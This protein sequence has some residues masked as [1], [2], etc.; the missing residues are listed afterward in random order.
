MGIAIGLDFGTT[1]SIVTYEDRKGRLR[2]YK[3]NGS[4]LIP[5]V[6][7]FKTKDDYII[8]KNALALRNKNF[9]GAVEGFKMKLNE[10]NIPY[11][12]TLEDGS[13]Y[14]I[15]PRRVVSLFLNSLMRQVQEYLS[16]KSNPAADFI[17]DRAVI[18]VP[19]KFN[20][21]AKT[22]IKVAA[23]QAMNLGLGQVKLVYEPTAAAVAAQTEEELDATRLLI[24]DFG[25][26]TFD[27]S[28]IQKDNGIFK[29]IKTDGDPE[30][31]GNLLT[32]I[33]AEKLLE[34]ANE[35]Y[36]TNFPW[37]SDEFDEEICG[38]SDSQYKA[39]IFN[40]MKAANEAKISLSEQE[41]VTVT[42]EF[43]T[44]AEKSENYIVDV[45]KKSFEKLIRDK[46]NHT[47]EIT[48]RVVNS[49]EAKAIGGI[50][51]IIIAGGSGQIPM[52]DEV[53]KDKLG[54]FP[55]SRSDNISTLISRGAAIL[56][57]DIETLEKVTAQKTTVQYG[58]AM[59][60]GMGY[61]IF[62][63]IVDEGRDLPCEGSCDF[64]LLEDGQRYLKI[65][66]YE[67]DIKN[68]P[69]A[70]QTDDDGITQIDELEIELPPNLKKA[71]TLVKITFAVQR[72]SSIEFSAKVL[73]ESGQTVGKDSIKVNKVSDLF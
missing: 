55:I 4:P 31:G 36:E 16:S 30:C 73:T 34:W 19:T 68:Y 63:T 7:Y 47:A 49:A 25:G 20:D 17:I 52:I 32:N 29:Q 72:D 21:K 53:L 51:K 59:T 37:D 43:W 67:R 57:K 56:A 24:Y 28:L 39:N 5:S 40:I 15:P 3:Q 33:L 54:N 69:N 22:A 23:A 38:I 2:T 48:R 64:K 12:L 65:Y 11:E 50:D 45:S 62:Q 61:G 8:G 1:N 6:I 71:D 27:V 14:R 58:V 9:A 10:G 35:E 44:A 70:M 60:E 41:E 26:G 66:Y 42:F 18:T 13:A 46:I